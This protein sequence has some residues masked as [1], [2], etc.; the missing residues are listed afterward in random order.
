MILSHTPTQQAPIEAHKA[1]QARY[2]AAARNVKQTPTAPPRRP[3]VAR[4]PKA[5]PMW[6]LMP[7]QFDAHVTAYQISQA[8]KVN[9]AGSPIKQYIHRRCQE[10]GM[11]MNKVLGNSRKRPLV[12]ARQLLIWEVKTQVKPTITL[13]ELGRVFGGRDHTTCLH[14]LRRVEAKRARAA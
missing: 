13:P 1:R 6:L 4:M 12:E 8:V 2:A 9:L 11:D 7:I 3:L 10:M 5:V 14:A